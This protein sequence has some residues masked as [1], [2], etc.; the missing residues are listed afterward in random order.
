M[1]YPLITNGKRPSEE[2]E[3]RHRDPKLNTRSMTNTAATLK[4]V[5]MQGT[6]FS[7]MEWK[8]I[9]FMKKLIQIQT[10]IIFL[11]KCK[12]MDIVPKGLKISG[13]ERI[14]GLRLNVWKE[15]LDSE[16][17]SHY[18]PV[19]FS[20]L[21]PGAPSYTPNSSSPASAWS[22]LPHPELL[23]SGPTLLPQPEPSPPPT[24]QPQFLKR[25]LASTP[26]TLGSLKQKLWALIAAEDNG[27]TAEKMKIK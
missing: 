15:I 23:I 26:G 20:S 2:H 21:R 12:Q 8:S 18:C 25:C 5:I 13:H 10:D 27:K 24:P 11:S 3:G 16:S 14:F 6:E 19:P 17:I 9:N 4:L 22:P 7:R 1:M